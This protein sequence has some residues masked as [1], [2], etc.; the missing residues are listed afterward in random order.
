MKI[1]RG[2]RWF[3][4]AVMLVG[5]SAGCGVRQRIAV[6]SMVPILENTAEAARERDDIDMVAQ[7]FPANLLLLD[8]LIR[9][10]GDNPEL[11][12]LGSYLYFNY[13]LGFVEGTN[14]TQASD[15]YALGHDYGLRALKRHGSFRKKRAKNL[16]AFERG[17]KDLKEDDVPAMAWTAANWGR[18]L[19]LNLDTPAAI[20]DM[21]RLELLLDRLLALDPGYKHG[22]PEALRG[23]Y[24]ATK[25]ALF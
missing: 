13:A 16:E 20:A 2:L 25:P 8:G 4:A 17:V 6:G 15:Y 7:A 10:D 14:P 22:L 9:T 24:D 5:S 11:L 12:H 1:L 3:V 18:W 21:P 19:S 23:I